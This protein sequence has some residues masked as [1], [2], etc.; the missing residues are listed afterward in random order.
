MPKTIAS[1]N[2]VSLMVCLLFFFNGGSG[3]PLLWAI[4]LPSL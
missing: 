2:I 1:P 3:F 4:L